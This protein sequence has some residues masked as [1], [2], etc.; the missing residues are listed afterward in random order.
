MK[1][2]IL[3]LIDNGLHCI[4]FNSHYILSYQI[5]LQ[6]DNLIIWFNLWLIII[7][8]NNVYWSMNEKEINEKEIS[9]KLNFREFLGIDLWWSN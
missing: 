5:F 9:E 7:A 2:L 6:F 8:K 4:K 1:E 3:T